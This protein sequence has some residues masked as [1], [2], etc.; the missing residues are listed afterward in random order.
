MFRD[1]EIFLKKVE[2]VDS[3]ASHA[4]PERETS[5]SFE[6]AERPDI[7]F[8]IVWDILRAVPH[9]S[10]QG[11][12]VRIQPLLSAL[13]NNRRLFFLNR[14]GSISSSARLC[15]LELSNTRGRFL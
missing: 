11:A 5:L 4:D 8:V 10:C 9:G 3:S 15:W 6:V 1:S 2:E 7:L 14:L 13:G 12:S